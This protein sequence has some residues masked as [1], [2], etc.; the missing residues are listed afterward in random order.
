DRSRRHVR[1]EILEE[2]ALPVNRIEALGLI[3]AQPHHL[4]RDDL[5]ARLLE[6]FVDLA[7]QVLRDTVGLDDGKRTF[8]RHRSPAVANDPR[9]ETKKKSAGPRPVARLDAEAFAAT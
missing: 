3:L 5:E 7:D 2:R 6:T 4:R 9:G 8:N 1:D